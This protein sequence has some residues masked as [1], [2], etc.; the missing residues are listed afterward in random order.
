VEKL[1]VG[2]GGKTKNSIGAWYLLSPVIKAI[3]RFFV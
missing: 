1:K 2:F 3:I